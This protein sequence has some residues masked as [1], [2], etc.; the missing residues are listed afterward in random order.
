MAVRLLKFVKRDGK[1]IAPTRGGRMLGKLEEYFLEQM[2]Y[3]DTFM[4]GGQIVRFE[5]IRENEAIVTPTV[6]KDPMVPMY[7]GSKFPLSTYLAQHIRAMMAEPEKWKELPKQVSEW[8][9]IQSAKSIMPSVDELL[10]ETFPR[11]EKF[12]LVW[13]KEDE[14]TSNTRLV[15]D[16]IIETANQ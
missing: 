13:P 14:P 12:Y 6:S 3:G 16:W 5:G 4:F 11:G 1:G 15:R 7:A 10:V 9:N 8:L 2:V